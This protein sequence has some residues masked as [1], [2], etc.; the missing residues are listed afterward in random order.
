MQP[1]RQKSYLPQSFPE[2]AWCRRRRGL[3]AFTALGIH[4]RSSGPAP[5]Q[6]GGAGCGMCGGIWDVV[7]VTYSTMSSARY[8]SLYYLRGPLALTRLHAARPSARPQPHRKKHSL[9]P[10]LP[11][12]TRSIFLFVP[13]V[14][15]VSHRI[16]CWAN[17][18]GCQDSCRKE[19]A[20]FEK[21]QRKRGTECNQEVK[22]AAAGGRGQEESHRI[23]L[24]MPH[25]PADVCGIVLYTSF[26]GLVCFRTL[27]FLADG[28]SLS[29][30]DRIKLA[31]HLCLVLSALLEIGE[32]AER[33]EERHRQRERDMT[34]RERTRRQL[35]KRRTTFNS[36]G[37][38]SVAYDIQ[39]YTCTH[40]VRST[41]TRIDKN[42]L[43]L[44][45]FQYRQKHA[46]APC[47]GIDNKRRTNASSD[48]S[49]NLCCERVAV[50]YVCP[51]SC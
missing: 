32:G 27:P 35:H 46:V 17:Q 34:E 9:E 44:S 22:V 25:D 12:N 40:T 18:R 33:Q 19:T 8:P 39:Q 41:C 45:M 14:L 30:T 37:L 36:N 10:P 11:L 49:F 21:P 51:D 5:V 48:C 38:L 24:E 23:A 1:S 28:C 16:I 29:S 2:N 31:F 43:L 4:R 20:S 50:F 3:H 13:P 26:F 6:S 47:S 15:P 7:G 42:M